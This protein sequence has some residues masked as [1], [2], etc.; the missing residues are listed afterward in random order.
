MEHLGTLLG[1]P[2]DISKFEKVSNYTVKP[3]GGLWVAPYDL[4]GE[5]ISKWH[6]F[7]ENEYYR[8]YNVTN[9]Y[10][11]E[12][13]LKK[14]ARILI[15]DSY[16]DLENLLTKNPDV[17]YKLNDNIFPDYEKLSTMYDMMYVTQKGVRE[18]ANFMRPI[19][20]S[21]WQFESGLIMNP[22]AID[23]ENIKEIKYREILPK[24]A[25]YEFIKN[26]ADDNYA[27]NTIKSI[28]QNGID[29]SEIS[30]INEDT[31][32]KFGIFFNRYLNTLEIMDKSEERG[33]MRI[34]DFI[35]E[36]EYSINKGYA[37]FLNNENIGNKIYQEILEASI[38]I[39]DFEVAEKMRENMEFGKRIEAQIKYENVLEI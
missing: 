28:I 15:I 5:Y 26:T 36:F 32:K 6:E 16:E 13:P 33:Q 9:G 23:I 24:F 38:N 7:L 1:S 37:I 29:Y 35:N 14:D 10:F 2:F 21:N 11:Y 17:Q 25:N 20:L 19:N 4:N 39:N 12:I 30:I 34:G 3:L 18:T 22:E 27:I 8:T 31:Q